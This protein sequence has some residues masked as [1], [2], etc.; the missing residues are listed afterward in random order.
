MG[1]GGR[2]LQRRSG[3]VGL[4]PLPT[5]EGQIVQDIAAGDERSVDFQP[6]LGQELAAFIFIVRGNLLAEF[7]T[8]FRL[9]PGCYLDAAIVLRG[10]GQRLIGNGFDFFVTN[11]RA[12]VVISNAQMVAA[13]IAGRIIIHSHG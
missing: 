1:A 10:N 4:R 13:V 11:I 7:E 8:N 9:V 2:R 5:F 6:R 12:I 3:P